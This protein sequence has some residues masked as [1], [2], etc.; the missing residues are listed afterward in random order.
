MMD[1]LAVT[2]HVATGMRILPG[3]SRM[4]A[5]DR[6]I[7]VHTKLPMIVMHP[8]EHTIGK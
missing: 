6:S 2:L 7:L 3:T 1:S 8:D 5:K 4:Q